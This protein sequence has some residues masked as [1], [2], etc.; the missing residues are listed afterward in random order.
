MTDRTGSLQPSNQVVH[1]GARPVGLSHPCFIIAEAGVNHNGSKQMAKELVDV[2]AAAG[3]DAVKFQTF[4]TEELVAPSTPKAEYQEKALGGDIDQFEMLKELEL[5]DKVFAELKVYCESKGVMFLS[6]P[7]DMAS[8]DLLEDIGV[9]AYKVSSGDLTNHPLLSRLSRIGKPVIL[10][11]GMSVL[12]EVIE[13]LE[14]VRNDGESEVILLH[15]TTQYPTPPEEVNLSAMRSLGKSTG[16]LTGFSDHTRGIDIASASVALGACVLEK[17]FTLDRNLKG[18][19]HAA[20]LEPSELEA[21][22]VSVRRVETAMGREEKKPSQNELDVAKV[23]RKSL[24]SLVRISRGEVI[25]PEMLTCRRPGTGLAPR[26]LE[27]FVG[28]EAL[29]DIDAGSPLR[30]EDIQ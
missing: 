16:Y 18:P 4:K 26:H 2:A 14:V 1:I 29:R 21:L 17:H 6:T 3:V 24:M 19:D 12:E 23:A 30:W 20:S 22:V 10:S 13:S 9:E 25:R 5:E 11:T 7:F 8:V 15:C 27:E 28:K